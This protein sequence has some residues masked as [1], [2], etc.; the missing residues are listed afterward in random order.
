MQVCLIFR[1]KVA[2]CGFLG[3]GFF[4]FN[5]TKDMLKVSA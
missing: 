3:G 5:I 2:E 4:V 1:Q